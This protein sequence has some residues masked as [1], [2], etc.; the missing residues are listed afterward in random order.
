M[1]ST[2]ADTATDRYVTFKGIDCDGNAQRLIERIF[3]IIDQP[4]NTNAF[5]EKFRAEVLAAENIH[6]R[7]FDGLC[8]LCARVGIIYE[9]FEDHDDEEGHALLD[10]L[11]NECC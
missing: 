9:L 5:W 3:A 4:G 8:L 10:Q 2:T 6:E 7:K 11:E 1:V